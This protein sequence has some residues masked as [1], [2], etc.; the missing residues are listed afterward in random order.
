MTCATPLSAKI[1]ALITLATMPSS[2]VKVIPES[3]TVAIKVFP[4]AVT[5]GPEVTSPDKIFRHFQ[6]DYFKQV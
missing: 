2:L 5:T 3:E 1:S 6:K 4:L